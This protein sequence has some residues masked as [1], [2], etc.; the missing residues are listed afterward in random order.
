MEHVLTEHVGLAYESYDAMIQKAFDMGFEPRSFDAVRVTR[1]VLRLQNWFRSR[2]ALKQNWPGAFVHAAVKPRASKLEHDARAV[3][4]FAFK[5][6]TRCVRKMVRHL[7]A[8]R[9]RCDGRE[10]VGAI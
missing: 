5:V 8:W 10:R 6:K 1:S 9:A 7:V 3:D 4:V 2:K